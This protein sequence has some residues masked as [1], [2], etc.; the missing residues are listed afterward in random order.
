MAEDLNFFREYLRLASRPSP[1]SVLRP[2][3]RSSFRET[4]RNTEL[5]FPLSF[6]RARTRRFRVLAHESFN[7]RIRVLNNLYDQRFNFTSIYSRHLIDNNMRNPSNFVNLC[8]P[9]PLI[10]YEPLSFFFFKQKNGE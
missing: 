8:V 9:L 3:L 10:A 5:S 7:K 4:K 1:P 6:P 2:C